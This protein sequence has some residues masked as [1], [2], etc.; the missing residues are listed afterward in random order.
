MKKILAILMIIIIILGSLFLYCLFKPI[1]IKE[2]TIINQNTNLKYGDKINLKIEITPNNATNKNVIWTSSN[3]ELV[4]V[5]QNGNVEVIKNI[6][7][8]AI[9]TAT[10]V[11]ENKQASIEITVKKIDSIIKVTGIKLSADST[12]L[13]YNQSTQL[14]AI[15]SPNNATNQNVTWTSSNSELVSVDQNGNVKAIKNIDGYSLITA[16]TVDG[17]KQAS[18]RIN[19]KK[20]DNTIKVTGI[21]LSADST[22]LNYNQSTQLKAIISPNNATN[23][24][25]IWTSS[26]SEL[27]SVDQ[28]GNVKTIKNIDGYSL[29]TATTVDG[30]KQASIRINT[31][32]VDNTIKVTG[33]K[34]N[35]S[36]S[37]TLYLNNSN[38]INLT[39][40]IIPNN[41][42]NQNV[43]W[44][45]S[46]T[47]VATVNSN[48]NVTAKSIGS[49]TIT[50]KTNDGNYTAT[51]KLTVKE[52]VIV[53]ITA[54]AGVRMNDWFKNYTSSSKNNYNTSN[55][56]LNYIFKSGSG[57]EYQYNEGLKTAIDTINNKYSD[58]KDYIDLSVFFTLTGNSVKTFSCDG[59][60]NSNDYKTFANKYNDAVQQ[61][62]NLGYKNSKGYVISHSPL[63]TKYAYN[64]FPDNFVKFKLTFSTNEN[65]CKAG[66]RS[67]YKYWLSNKKMQ[68]VLNTGSY[69]NLTFIDNFSNF[70]VINNETEK[71]FTWKKNNEGITYDTIYKT[72]DGLHWDEATTKIYMQLAF[73]TAEM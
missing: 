59:I 55:G 3:S 32:K 61:F 70:V 30:N 50:V 69:K 58:K 43:T 52:K 62:I 72:T 71:T 37:G 65:V 28:N 14:K 19:T 23:Q 73:D 63:N 21:K 68:S 26:N 40:T 67:A 56:T 8:S 66:Y 29:I 42:T 9:I 57:F 35:N 6:D 18:I 33:I 10:T 22:T 64:N 47:A 39:H 15:I 13:N 4:S 7:G 49:T 54:S 17:N 12:T 60:N 51:Y 46:N 44:T 31:K 1:D 11:D 53:V 25:V 34:I 5:D 20:V 2:I 45:S 38:Y 41:A 16:T 24:N 48:G 36:S 27:V